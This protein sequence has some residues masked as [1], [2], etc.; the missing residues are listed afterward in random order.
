MQ[1]FLPGIPTCLC[2]SDS[3]AFTGNLTTCQETL[4]CLLSGCCMSVECA[5]WLPEEELDV[6]QDQT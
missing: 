3:E 5:F 6:H 2:C 1:S 4:T